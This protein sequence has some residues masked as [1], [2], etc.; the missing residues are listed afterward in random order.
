MPTKSKRRKK[1]SEMTSKIHFHID[2]HLPLGPV[3]QVTPLRLNA[4]LKRHPGIAKKLRITMSS[5]GKGIDQHL[6][7]ADALFVWKVNRK[8]FAERAPRLRWVQAPGAGI[9]H[10]LPLD[11]LPKSAVL[12]NNSGVHVERASEYGIMAILMLNNRLPEIITNQRQARWDQLFN[13]RIAGKTLLVVGVGNVGGGIAK[14][15]KKF[16]LRVIGTRRTGKPHRHVDRMYHPRELGRVLPQADFVLVTAPSTPDTRHLIGRKE[17]DLMKKSTGIVC[18]SR[19][20]IIDYE[21]LRKKL[22]KR[23]L[24]AI[25]DVFDPEP[26]PKSSPLWKTPNLI[27]TPHCSSDDTEFYTPAT[28]DLTF[29]NM[30]RFIVGKPL[31]NRIDPKLGY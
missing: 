4:A 12:T 22:E 18:Y 19:A 8:N 5:N 15:A 29:R 17:L 1:S 11:W 16:G 2:N 31:L 27:I 25:I 10:L 14:W 28:L 30:E 23:Q 6:K 26:L 13:N 24:S 7:T 21:A 20:D 3:F 9:N